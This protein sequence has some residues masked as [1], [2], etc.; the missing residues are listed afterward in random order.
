[1]TFNPS[2]KTNDGTLNKVVQYFKFFLSKD[3]CIRFA[4]IAFLSDVNKPL[5]YKNT[6]KFTNLLQSHFGSGRSSDYITIRRFRT[7]AGNVHL[8]EYHNVWQED[9]IRI[10]YT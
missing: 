4:R 5:S 2:F 10:M 9:Y 7:E 3:C 1:M 8:L 6:L